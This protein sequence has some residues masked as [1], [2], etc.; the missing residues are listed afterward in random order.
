MRKLTVIFGLTALTALAAC[1]PT[2]PDSG[3]GVGF[4]DYIAYQAGPQANAGQTIQP[5]QTGVV[6]PATG[7]VAS[8]SDEQDFDAVSA[9]ETIESDAAR[10]AANR[11]VFEVVEVQD[12]PVRSGNSYSLVVEF[13]LA[14]NNSVGQSLY[15]RSGFFAEDRF[16]RNCA[17]YTSRDLAQE[18]F[19][20]RGGPERDPMGLD[21]D[22]DGFACFWSPEPFRQARFAA[23]PIEPVVAPVE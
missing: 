8:I 9:R 13:A 6:P 5:P 17:R 3:A 7:A 18:A 21:P 12:L 16:N 14:T 11:A 20:R 22:G 10:L 19:L 23:Q 4:S 15:N 2:I 1:T